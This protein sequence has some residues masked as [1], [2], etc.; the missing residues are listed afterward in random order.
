MAANT[1]KPN[2]GIIYVLVHPTMK[3]FVK[4]G[5]TQ[6]TAEERAKELGTTGL[7]GNFFVVFDIEVIDYS[8]IEILVH[9][10]LDKF[11]PVKNREFFKI[12]VKDAITC[13]NKVILEKE[14][15][16]AFDF[17]INK[18]EIWFNN[19]NVI[20]KQIFRKYLKKRTKNAF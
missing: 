4:I 7:V 13:I 2:K 18:P 5:K 3:D 19:Q 9:Q 15:Q 20:W 6:R 14:Q 17:D 16:K 10:K 12:S 11:R 1:I 8:L